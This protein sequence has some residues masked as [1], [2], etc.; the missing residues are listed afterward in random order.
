MLN[1][2]IS[3]EPYFQFLVVPCLIFI[4]RILDVS[5]ST[6]R[7][8]FVLGGK[9]NYATLLGFFEALI[10]IVAIGQ[11]MK[12]IT[13]VAAYIAYAGGFAGGT[14]V[15]MLIEE[16]LAVGKVIIRIITGRKAD[17]LI[18]FLKTA[19]YGVTSVEADGHDGKVNVI[20]TVIDRTHIE[21]V[22]SVIRKF[23]PKAFYTIENM[24]FVSDGGIRK[25]R[26]K[27][28]RK[29]RKVHEELH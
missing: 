24:R 19:E 11:I 23:N 17:A 27:L 16:K 4:A 29:R 6:I 14:F 25:E 5:M 22:V 15:G 18:H 2:L 1:K 3:L 13:N 9:K 20:Y 26:P 28:F 10:W 8:M 12:D 21:E 7:I